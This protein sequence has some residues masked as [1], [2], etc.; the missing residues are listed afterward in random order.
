MESDATE[1]YFCPSGNHRTSAGY[2]EHSLP[3]EVVRRRD[4][5]VDSS[6][7]W[8][9]K[10]ETK[11]KSTANVQR[12][13]T[14][15]NNGTPKSIGKK[16]RESFLGKGITKS[17]AAPNKRAFRTNLSTLCLTFRSTKRSSKLRL[18]SE[19]H[20][21]CHCTLSAPKMDPST[22]GYSSPRYSYRTTP[23]CDISTS[24]PHVFITTA[25]RAIRSEACIRT[26]A[27]LL[28]SRHCCVFVLRTHHLGAFFSQAWENAGRRRK[29]IF[30]FFVF[31]HRR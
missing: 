4:A 24:S 18:H 1:K 26:F 13:G 11:K 16:R 5:R 20:H 15:S 27:L 7:V 12:G 6:L 8:F 10:A 19:I 14:A 2:Q 28:L 9:Y 25:I 31:L 22:S 30:C 23:K 29:S 21:C 3:R 17:S